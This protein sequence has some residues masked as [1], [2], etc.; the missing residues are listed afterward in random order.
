MKKC[1]LNEGTKEGKGRRGPIEELREG[2]KAVPSCSRE[3]APVLRKCQALAML[4][5]PF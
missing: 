2:R 3:A 4:I 5:T 1:F